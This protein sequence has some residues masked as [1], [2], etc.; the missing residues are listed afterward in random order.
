MRMQ[1]WTVVLILAAGVACENESEPPST[2]TE[3]MV[4]PALDSDTRSTADEPVP[5][6][7]ALAD[8]YSA[9]HEDVSEWGYDEGEWTDDFGDGAAFG[10]F[11]FSNRWQTT[12]SDADRKIAEET[13]EYNL[14]VVTKASENVTWALDNLEEVFMAVQGVIEAAGVLDKPEGIEPLDAFI[15]E[16]MDPVVASLGDYADLSAGDFAADLYGPTSLTAG[17]AVIYSQYALRLDTD[18]TPQRLQR[19]GEILDAIHEKAWD[20][21]GN[22]YLFRPEND[23]MFLY[24]NGTMLIALNRV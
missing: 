14:S 6:E 23:T 20:A 11:Y 18:K 8:L 21:E 12:Q 16:V 7:P 3:G 4:N 17:V 19:A 24:P 5:T 9:L 15:D 2:S 22:R 10:A 13:F 1:L